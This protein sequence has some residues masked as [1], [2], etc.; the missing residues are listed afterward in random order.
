MIKPPAATTD[1]MTILSLFVSQKEGC[2]VFRTS[3]FRLSI[4]F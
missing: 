3:S 2:T 1:P 4:F